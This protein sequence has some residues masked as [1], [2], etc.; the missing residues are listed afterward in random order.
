MEEK[1]TVAIKKVDEAVDFVEINNTL[2]AYQAIVDGYIEMVG[3]GDDI[4]MVCDEEGKLKGKAFNFE[5]NGDY[6]VGDVFFVRVDDEGDFT[7]LDENDIYD[8]EDIIE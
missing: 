4:Y 5:L 1:I 6:I 2:E 7:S 3:I 8:I